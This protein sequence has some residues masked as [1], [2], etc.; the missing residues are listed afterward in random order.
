MILSFIFHPESHKWCYECPDHVPGDYGAWMRHNTLYPSKAQYTLPKQV[1]IA[2]GFSALWC[3]GSYIFGSEWSDTAF[4]LGRPSVQSGSSPG[5]TAPAQ[6]GR[7]L[8]SRSYAPFRF[9][10]CSWTRKPTSYHSCPRDITSG[11]HLIW[12]CTLHEVALEE[13]LEVSQY[14]R[15]VKCGYLMHA[16]PLHYL[17]LCFWRQLM[18]LVVTFKV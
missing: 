1:C 2:L 13:H 14:D 10:T 17:R 18:V 16:T 11:L 15:T 4:I 8:L 3:Q 7:Q 6:R 12:Q 5:F 9:C